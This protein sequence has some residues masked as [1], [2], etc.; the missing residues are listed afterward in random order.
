[1]NLFFWDGKS[2][3]E[4]LQTVAAGM[5]RGNASVPTMEMTKW[6][7]IAELKEAGATWIQ[8]NEKV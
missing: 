1:M 5:A 6:Q 8:F 4:D 3:A 7:V 2:S